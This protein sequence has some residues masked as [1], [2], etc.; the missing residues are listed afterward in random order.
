MS[1]L[2]HQW[3]HSSL[4]D[5]EKTFSGLTD[6]CADAGKAGCKLIEFTGDD[7]SGDDVK[8]LLN[9]AHDVVSSV[10]RLGDPADSVPV[11]GVPPALP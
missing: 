10:S 8:A 4:A 5:T 1:H 2:Q 3:L 9:N 7:A 11:S 6:A